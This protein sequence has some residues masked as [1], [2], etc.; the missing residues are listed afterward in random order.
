[1]SRYITKTIYLKRAKTSYNLEPVVYKSGGHI[2]AACSEL[3]H[4]LL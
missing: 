2:A 3:S 4:P 1:M